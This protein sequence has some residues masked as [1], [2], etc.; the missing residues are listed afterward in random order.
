MWLGRHEASDTVLA[1]V[2][3]TEEAAGRP[4]ADLWSQRGISAL[5]AGDN[6]RALDYF[7]RALA[8]GSVNAA[9]VLA[10]RDLDAGRRREA[11]IGF[12]ALSWGEE[13]GAWALRGWGLSLLPES[14]PSR[15]QPDRSK[16][17]NGQ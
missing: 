17:P 2:I 13:A 7:G 10:R 14:E 12:R 1:G 3:A 9:V 5:A 11:R 15:I 16:H 6:R 4:T 8:R